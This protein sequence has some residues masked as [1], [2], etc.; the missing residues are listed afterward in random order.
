[1]AD[2]SENRFDKFAITPKLTQVQAHAQAHAQAHVKTQAQSHTIYRCQVN[3]YMQVLQRGAI[4][5]SILS[6]WYEQ[7]KQSAGKTYSIH[8]ATYTRTQSETIKGTR[9]YIHAGI[10]FND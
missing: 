3:K 5:C 6:F 2:V 1:V 8:A 9:T 4:R 7:D 10:L